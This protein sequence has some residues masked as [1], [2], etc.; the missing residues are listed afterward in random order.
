[1]PAGSVSHDK[2]RRR[3]QAGP[4]SAGSLSA[5]GG[6]E[7]IELRSAG[8]KQAHMLRQ[9]CC[10]CHMPAVYERTRPEI[11]EGCC[12]WAWPLHAALASSSSSSIRQRDR[13]R[14]THHRVYVRCYS[15]H[16]YG[17]ISSTEEYECMPK[18]L[19]NH[20]LLLQPV[21]VCTVIIFCSCDQSQGFRD[22]I[23]SFVA[24][25]GCYSSR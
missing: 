24:C 14:V 25:V 2:K 4:A 22:D 8:R 10:L 21:C 3:R 6:G 23:S 7:L 15:I 20:I 13:V 12:L 1:M 19:R 5:T 17:A 18:G 9:I 11:G 16:Q